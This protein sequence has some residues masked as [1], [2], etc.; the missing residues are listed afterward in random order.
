MIDVFSEIYR[1]NDN[2]AYDGEQMDRQSITAAL[3]RCNDGAEVITKS[4]FQRFMGI[5]KADHVKKYFADLESIDGKYY[6]VT[7]LAG[8]LVRR[9]KQPKYR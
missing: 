1:S 5:K 7:D 4:E 3:K 2:A 9:K 8:E 6:L